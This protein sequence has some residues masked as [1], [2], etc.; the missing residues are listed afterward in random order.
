MGL[1]ALYYDGR[2]DPP[3]PEI[4]LSYFARM[5]ELHANRAL[6]LVT[7][8]TSK[9]AEAGA[10]FLNPKERK[11]LGYLVRKGIAVFAPGELAKPLKVTNRM[12]VNWCA[13]LVRNGF[14]LPDTSGQR[15]RSYEVTALATDAGD[16][17]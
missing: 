4:W 5:M 12:I 10:S 7:D 8:G 11:F 2:A 3:H 6:E 1:P 16:A 14:L 17:G 9:Q 13:A 15:I